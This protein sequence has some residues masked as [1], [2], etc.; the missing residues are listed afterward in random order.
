MKIQG[1]TITVEAG[2][3][4]RITN[5]EG[6]VDYECDGPL[7]AKVYK[8]ATAEEQADAQDE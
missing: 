3:W 8:D 7:V 6:Y 4:I 5:D 1:N 2:E